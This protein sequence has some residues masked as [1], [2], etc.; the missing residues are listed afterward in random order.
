M[1]LVVQKFGGTSVASPGLI[2][3]AAELV[4]R[5]RE[6]GDA[7]VMVVSAM[8]Q[9]TD[10]LLALAAAVNVDPGP[11]EMDLLLASG[12][13]VSCALAAM[14]L[15]ARGHR[16]RAYLGGQVRIVTDSIFRRAHIREVE[17]VRLRADLEAGRIPVVAGFQGV[18]ESGELTT[19]GRGG[20]DTTAVA[21]AAALDADEC[22]IMTD[23]D[24]VYTAD[25]RVVPEA[26]RL[27][28]LSFDEM[29][30]L[31]SLGSKVLQ[32][33]AVK[34]ARKYGVPVR[35]LHMSGEGPGTLI[36]EED[37]SLEA[38]VISGIVHNAEE[39]QIT[40]AGLP[41][42]P[43]AIAMLLRH[44]ADANIP[45]DMMVTGAG[46]DGRMDLA[47]SVQRPDY[48]EALAL[49]RAAVER[50]GAGEV[51]GDDDVAKISVVGTGI[52]SHAGVA[53][54]LFSTLA[55]KK[56]NVRMVSTSEIKISV[57]IGRDGLDEG[58]RSLHAAFELDRPQPWAG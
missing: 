54:L 37:P 34:F 35:V 55:E 11:R 58:V 25:P 21:L 32:A 26:R 13:Q 24:G 51:R 31:A 19:F 33:R 38:A 12:E 27:D 9:A 14:A 53:A 48:R 45:V 16:S 39:A 57:L 1:A 8:G 46:G 5:R 2:R 17:T 42:G 29:L 20:S 56:I 18:D 6:A 7:V 10:E 23:V 15:Q 43:A 40:V 50:M 52:R 30:E 22:Q 4:A 47:F 41:D 3:Q 44:L 36:R 28:A 49:A